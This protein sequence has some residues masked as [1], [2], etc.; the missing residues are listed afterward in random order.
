MSENL[1]ISDVFRGC[2]NGI[3]NINLIKWDI[4]ISIKRVNHHFKFFT[5]I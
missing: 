3:L 1:M 2:K 5:G 4:N